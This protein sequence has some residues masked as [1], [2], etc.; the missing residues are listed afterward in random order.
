MN[1]S[2]PAK[3][4]THLSDVENFVIQQ[5][6]APQGDTRAISV[7]NDFTVI[8]PHESLEEERREL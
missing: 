2:R 1:K 6:F 8:V 4:I 7:L 5:L 3:R